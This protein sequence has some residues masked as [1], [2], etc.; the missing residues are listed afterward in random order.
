V[1]SNKEIQSIV[2]IGSGNVATHLSLA[3][4]QAGLKIL[5]IYGQNL[6]HAKLL[7]NKLDASYTADLRSLSENADLYL[8]AITDSAIQSVL[9]KRDWKGKLLVHT[10]GSISL[11]I[12]KTIS[13]NFGVIF[14]LQ[15]FSKNRSID[16]SSV[17]FF[18]E[19]NSSDTLDVLKKLVYKISKN[20]SAISFKDRL[21]LHLAAVF[22]NNFSNHMLTVAADILK[23]HKL[24]IEYLHPLIQET[25]MKAIELGPVSAQTGPAVRNN[26]EIIQKHITLLENEPELQNLYKFISENIIK[27]HKQ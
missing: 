11:N 17:P 22:A 16:I 23:K 24:P 26:F 8:F 18:I 9:D 5:Q 21:I 27:Y 15:T 10:A 13:E 19:A 4:Y 2:V 14:P 20:V 12:F 6:D 7:A 1:A 3:F 25:S